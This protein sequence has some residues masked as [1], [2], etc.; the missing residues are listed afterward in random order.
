MLLVTWPTSAHYS[1]AQSSYPPPLET[2][3]LSSTS[4]NSSTPAPQGVILTLNKYEDYLC[5]TQSAKS[6]SITFVAHTCNVS[7][8]LTHAT[9]L[10]PWILDFGSPDH[11]SGNKDFFSSLT[12]TSSLLIITSTNGTQTIPKGISSTHPLSSLSLTSILYVL[13][14]PFKLISISKVTH[15]LNCLITFFDSSITLDDQST[16]END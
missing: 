4:G 11:L 7:T 6:A 10:D 13:D 15:D 12:I 8:C 16:E 9:S 3:T 14:S 1:M 5:L 2:K